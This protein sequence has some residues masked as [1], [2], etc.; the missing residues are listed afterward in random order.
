MQTFELPPQHEREELKN[1]AMEAARVAGNILQAYSQAGFTV[2]H[3]HAID[4]VTDADRASEQAIIDCIDRRYANHQILTEEQGFKST[5]QSPYRWIV[6]PLDGTT[7]FAHGLGIYCVSI[8]LEYDGRIIL[9]VVF[10]PSRQ[11]LFL[12]EANGGA[13]V[14]DTPL[15]VSLVNDLNEALLVTGFA[16]DIRDT[17]DNNLDHFAQFSLR[18][19]SVRRLGSAA[20]DLCY[21]AS[22]RLDGFWELKLSP[23]D[24]AAGSLIVREAGGQVTHFS[25]TSF[26]V[27][28]KQVLASNGL[29]HDQMLG[30]LRT[31]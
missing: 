19:Q 16:Y 6:D 17:S 10:D 21:V 26:S 14:N 5:G 29:I 30:V 22:G 18:A 4:L 9:G 11:E 1:T 2:Q 25:G 31:T 28:G 8:A 23:W 24:M 13:A 3:K 12:G 20:L 7:N 27:Y 15:C